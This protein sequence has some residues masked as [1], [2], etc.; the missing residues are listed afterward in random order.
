MSDHVNSEKQRLLDLLADQALFGLSAEEQQELVTLSAAYPDVDSTEMDRIVGLLEASSPATEQPAMPEA[1]KKTVLE[2]NG[3]APNEIDSNEMRSAADLG[4]ASTR[5]QTDVK[6]RPTNG[7]RSSLVWLAVAAAIGALLASFSF[8]YWHQNN[9]TP[10]L[11]VVQ[12]KQ[13]LEADGTDLVQVAWTPTDETKPYAG[14]VIWSNE[15]QKG[16]MTFEGLPV[17]DP[18]K[19][20]YQLWIFD[21]DQDERYPIDGGV[22]DIASGKATIPIDAKIRVSKPT[23]FAITIEKRGGVVVSDRSRLPLIAKL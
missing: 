2:S 9:A 23:M 20:Q 5:K 8:N 21:A 6:G 1:I 17:N 4:Q 12:Q 18:T 19:E 14:N 3:I 11:S 7:S 22:F 15:T 13:Q 16:F 10:V